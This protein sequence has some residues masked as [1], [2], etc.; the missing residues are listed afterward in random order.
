[1]ARTEP[2]GARN[3]LAT[4]NTWSP[5]AREAS[6]QARK[7][8][9]GEHTKL[10]QQASGN[11]SLAEESYHEHKTA[12]TKEAVG[13][14]HKKAADAHEQAGHMHSEAGDSEK[15][16]KHWD[17]AAEHRKAAN[18]WSPK[19]GTTGHLQNSSTASAQVLRNEDDASGDPRYSAQKKLDLAQQE[20]D[21]AEKDVERRELLEKANKL[22]A[23]AQKRSEEAYKAKGGGPSVKKLHITAAMAHEDA[24]EAFKGLGGSKMGAEL[25]ARGKASGITEKHTAEAEKH[26]TI[27]EGVGYLKR[28]S[29]GQLVEAGTGRKGVRVTV[30]TWSDAARQASA[31]AR[32]DHS[33]AAVS[34]SRDTSSSPMFSDKVGGEAQSKEWHG[35]MA[36]HHDK[37]ASRLRGGGT[38][39]TEFQEGLMASAHEKAANAHRTAAGDSSKGRVSVESHVKSVDDLPVKKHGP[40]NGAIEKV[41]RKISK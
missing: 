25:D 10:A 6:A 14:A 27:A 8:R 32:K 7:D 35:R 28:N 23:D 37:E 39:Y 2:T 24:A 13:L 33:K 19:K 11:A 22:R 30:N 40:I 41:E 31:L 9:A 17:L 21:A 1:M 38:G 18:A 4:V 16:Q 3:V 15:K 20:Y 5:E 12:R 34:A 26:R 36:E 29:S